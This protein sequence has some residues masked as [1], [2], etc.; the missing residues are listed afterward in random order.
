MNTQAYHT[1][2]EHIKDLTAL[3]DLMI[4]KLF[5]QEESA[6]KQGVNKYKGLGITPDDVRGALGMGNSLMTSDAELRDRK[7]VV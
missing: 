7:S 3:L 1:S 5:L 2:Q 4:Y 6:Q